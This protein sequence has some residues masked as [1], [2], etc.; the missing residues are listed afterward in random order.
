[1]QLINAQANARQV[2]ITQIN[3]QLRDKLLAGAVIVPRAWAGFWMT[4]R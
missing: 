3:I 1:M 2:G 4:G